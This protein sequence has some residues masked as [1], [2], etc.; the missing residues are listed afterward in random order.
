MENAGI[1]TAASL[2]SSMME[3]LSSNPQG[4]SSSFDSLSLPAYVV[5]GASE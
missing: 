2:R 1:T 4:G 3:I 5:P